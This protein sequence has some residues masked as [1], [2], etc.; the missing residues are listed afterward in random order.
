MNVINS[1]L[2]LFIVLG[3]MWFSIYFYVQIDI[4]TNNT[5][6]TI[7][8]C[9]ANKWANE[10]IGWTCK[11]VKQKTGWYNQCYRKDEK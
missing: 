8:Y 9:Y 7:G 3:I 4:R 5:P 11:C 6:G 2:K 1:I 10:D